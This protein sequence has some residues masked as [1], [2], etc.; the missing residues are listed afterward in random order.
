M[1]SILL[2]A[3][4]CYIVFGVSLSKDAFGGLESYGNMLKSVLD[5]TELSENYGTLAFGEYR[6]TIIEP[7]GQVVYDSS[8]DK[9]ENEN[10]SDRPEVEEALESGS[11][12]ISR[13]SSTLGVTSYYYAVKLDNGNVLRVSKEAHMVLN[14]LTQILPYLLAVVLLVFWV[15]RAI[16]SVTTKNIIKPI[17]QMAKSTDKI[18]YEEFIPFARTIEKQR[19]EI[20]KKI[21]DIQKE[22]VK[23]ETLIAN[24]SE[25][26]LLLDNNGKILTLND[27]IIS[28]FEMDK[29]RYFSGQNI[30]S[31]D[32]KDDIRKSI[33]KA[34]NGK[35]NTIETEE[36]GRFIKLHTNPVLSGKKQTGVICIA[37]DNS[38]LHSAEKMRREFSANVSHELKTPLTSI[39][40]YA[41]MIECGIAK[42][43]DI[44][45][46]ASKIRKEAARLVTLIG[47]I[48]KL[49]ELEETTDTGSEFV[50]VDLKNTAEECA[51]VLKLNAEKHN[52]TLKVTGDKAVVKGSKSMLYEL[53]YNLCD[54]AIRYNRDN[55]SVEISVI[56]ASKNVILQVSD[57]GIGIPEKYQMRVFERFYRVD[58]S[59]SKET[60]GTGLGLAIVKHIAQMHGA[61]LNINSKE[62]EGT[63]ISVAIPV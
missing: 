45:N 20:A 10:H 38:A 27:S 19:K 63:I 1:I 58:K 52:I 41:E 3:A 56:K 8:G 39:S 9:S 21:S 29:N 6:I 37:I 25:G 40:G 22:K 2:T 4:C 5:D 46:F 14:T 36:N 31:L 61:S 47:D 26:F 18:A 24:M 12:K 53:V 32:I 23:I 28:I 17:E 13:Y 59:R 15:C 43:D 16:S 30:S 49:S 57:T 7:D 42:E 48:I 11:G 50:N 44:K 55:G 51:E 62:N 54:N 34:L 35:S 60:G 33:H